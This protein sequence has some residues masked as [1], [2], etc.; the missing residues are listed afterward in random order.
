LPY[1]TKGEILDN[2]KFVLNKYDFVKHISVYM[3]EEYY[4]PDKIIE[5]KYD[6][7]TYPKDWDRL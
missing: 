2:I 4:N 3:L 6:N 5:T 7:V 1:V